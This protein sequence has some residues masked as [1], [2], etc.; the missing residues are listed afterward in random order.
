MYIKHIIHFHCKCDQDNEIFV[1]F[2]SSHPFGTSMAAVTDH[3]G[4]IQK[5]YFCYKEHANSFCQYCC[6]IRYSKSFCCHKLCVEDYEYFRD[7]LKEHKA[8]PLNEY[9]KKLP[10]EPFFILKTIESKFV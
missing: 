3:T 10:C 2:C 5:K 7:F 9:L 8:V 6:S 4:S 1:Y